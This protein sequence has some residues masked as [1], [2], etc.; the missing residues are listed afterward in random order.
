MGVAVMRQAPMRFCSVI[1]TIALCGVLGCLGLE[2]IE[3]AHEMRWLYVGPDTPKATFGSLSLSAH[4]SW[5]TGYVTIGLLLGNDGRILRTKILDS[6]VSRPM[7]AQALE[8][9][10]SWE[11]VPRDEGRSEGCAIFY[12]ER[13]DESLNIDKVLSPGSL[14]LKCRGNFPELLRPAAPAPSA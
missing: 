6:N 9:L 2:R 4:S 12:F 1:L 8:S 14:S 3:R 13:N 10:F 7:E 11:F 5:E